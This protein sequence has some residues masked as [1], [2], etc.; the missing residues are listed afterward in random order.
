MKVRRRE[1]EFSI[2]CESPCHA[3]KDEFVVLRGHACHVQ[4]AAEETTADFF[5][6]ALKTKGHIFG[7]QNQQ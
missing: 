4:K 1:S 7:L 3:E 5:C 6:F 2:Y